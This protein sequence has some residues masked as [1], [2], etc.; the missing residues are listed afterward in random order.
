MTQTGG[1]GSVRYLRV[2]G[3]HKKNR[4]YLFSTTSGGW[5]EDFAN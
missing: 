2:V 1:S 3:P 4:Q 5:I